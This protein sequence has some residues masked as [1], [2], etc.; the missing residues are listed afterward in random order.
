MI[1]GCV[2]DSVFLLDGTSTQRHFESLQP[3]YENVIEPI[4]GIKVKY[5]LVHARCS[6]AQDTVFAIIVCYFTVF[7]VSAMCSKVLHYITYT[8]RERERICLLPCFIAW[9]ELWE[10][11]AKYCV[12]HAKI[13][14]V[15][16]ITTM[17]NATYSK[18]FFY[19]NDR[20][21]SV[22]INANLQEF[23][24]SRQNSKRKISKLIW[25]FMH[26]SLRHKWHYKQINKQ[27]RA[28]NQRVH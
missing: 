5:S 2:C 3:L 15:A 22:L 19:S 28:K 24:S 9:Y 13:S 10:F 20:F 4:V 26:I 7:P 21:R 23:K 14:A 25:C 16:A 1:S 27:Q 17:A 18:H 6:Y 11:T 8:Q 12:E